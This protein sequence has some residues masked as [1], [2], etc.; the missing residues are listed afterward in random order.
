VKPATIRDTVRSG[1][2]LAAWSLA[3]ALHANAYA[4]GESWSALPSHELGQKRAALRIGGL[5]VSVAVGVR[6]RVDGGQLSGFG[7]QE[8]PPVSGD[9]REVVLPLVNR[10]D[11]AQLEHEVRI[12]VRIEGFRAVFGSPALRAARARLRASFK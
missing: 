4:G 7:P 5:D 10:M 9:S 12:R 11:G 6:G 8:V 2:A 3:L 1:A